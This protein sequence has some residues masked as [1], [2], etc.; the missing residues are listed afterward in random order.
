MRLL[1]FIGLFLLG[2]GILLG[3]IAVDYWL[4]TAAFKRNLFE[5]YLRNGSLIALMTSILALFWKDIDKNVELISWN[6]LAYIAA[7]LRLCSAP[8]SILGPKISALSQEAIDR[9]RALYSDPHASIIVAYARSFEI[10]ASALTGL[11]IC[12]IAIAWLLLVVPIQYFVYLVCGALPRVLSTD[13][14]DAETEEQG[15]EALPNG[16]QVIETRDGSANA[17]TIGNRAVSF[18]ALLSAAFIL[19]LKSIFLS[20]I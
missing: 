7:H 6:P 14:S 20:D 16:R 2:I 4:L 12:A 17:N 5:W 18:T 13:L 1:K 11:I 10:F 19:F 8:F 15:T 9:A 3:V